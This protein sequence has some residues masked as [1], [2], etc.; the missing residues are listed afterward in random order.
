VNVVT[1]QDDW[2]S[3]VLLRAMALPDGPER[4]AAG[5]G[6]LARCFGLDRSH[7]G[8]PAQVASGVWL[9][10]RP[11]GLPEPLELVQT[12]RIGVA[13][14]EEIPWRWYLRS[15][16]SVSRRA[17][18]DRPPPPQRGWGVRGAVVP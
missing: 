3:G 8:L 4:A 14:G 15:S 13:R 7:D 17:P 6:L 11:P 18:G 9:A 10:P 1:A 2:A 16:R 5:P 12:T